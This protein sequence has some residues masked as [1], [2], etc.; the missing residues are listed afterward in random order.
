V[1]EELVISRVSGWTMGMVVGLT[2]DAS[3]VL[4]VP[5]CSDYQLG[6][7]LRWGEITDL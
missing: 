5:V 4:F 1:I 2:S 7:N 3:L 6:S